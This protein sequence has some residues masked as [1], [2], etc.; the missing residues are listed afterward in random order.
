M[1]GARQ[2]AWGASDAMQWGRRRMFGRKEKVN[3]H[4]KSE[5]WPMGRPEV[6]ETED[7]LQEY[8]DILAMLK[9]EPLQKN[10]RQFKLIKQLWIESGTLGWMGWESFA[11]KYRGRRFWERRSSKSSLNIVCSSLGYTLQS[12]C[13][14]DKLSG[15]VWSWSHIWQLPY[16]FY[17]PSLALSILLFPLEGL[18]TLKEAGEHVG[19]GSLEWYQ[20]KK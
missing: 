4:L 5:L 11:S 9:R 17:L 6:L 10:T 7:K 14:P 15:Q 19:L 1:P 13:A 8:W 2:Q 3:V 18:P 12:P 20:L 16:P